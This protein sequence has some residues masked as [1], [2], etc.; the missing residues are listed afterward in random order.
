MK[1]FLKHFVIWVWVPL[2]IAG[3]WQLY[4]GHLFM[5]GLLFT[6]SLVSSISSVKIQNL[7]I[8]NDKKNS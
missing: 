3:Y 8:T 1:T 7:C 4:Q 6:I 5:A 2:L